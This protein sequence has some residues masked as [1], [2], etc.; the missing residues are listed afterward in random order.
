VTLAEKVLLWSSTLVVGVSG[1]VYAWMKYLLTPTDPY[2]AVHHPWQP[3]VLKV[4]LVAAPVLVFAVGLVFM[5]HVWRQ[6]R[7]DLKRGRRSGTG[8]LLTLVPMVLSG[9]LIQTVTDE[10]WLWWLAA[11]H[12]GT[13]TLFVLGFAAHQV[14]MW[15]RQARARRRASRTLADNR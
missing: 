9:T 10:S 7:S 4:H 1:F 15:A 14:S 11:I 12:L 3:L 2:S 5:Q 8:T 6:F 13:G